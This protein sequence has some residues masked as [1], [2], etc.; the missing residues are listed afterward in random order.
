MGGNGPHVA[1]VRG[2]NG[3]VLIEERPAAFG[4]KLCLVATRGPTVF[5]VLPVVGHPLLHDYTEA[6]RG[7]R[8][9]S[10]Q[11]REAI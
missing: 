3:A 11:S 8:A 6:V 2:I 5:R 10:I 7:H 4:S 9:L 1:R